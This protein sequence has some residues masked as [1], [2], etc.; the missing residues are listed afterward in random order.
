MAIVTFESIIPEILPSVP[1]CTDLIIVRALRRA[2]EEFLSK[3]LLWRINL[4]DHNVILG[5]VDVELEVPKSDLRIV[6]LKSIK[7]GTQETDIPQIADSQTPPNLS[8]TFCSLVDFG[9]TLRLTPV[10]TAAVT[11]KIRAVLSTTSKST[12]V[13][14]AVE[15]EIHE[16]LIDGSLARLYAMPGMPWADSSLAAYH[17]AIFQAAI[18]EMRGRAENNNGRAVRTVSYGG[19]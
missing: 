4:E 11:L 1:E 7:S 6:Q 14:S 12:G 3:S 10:P 2:S 18:I 13:D 5:L 17:G 8:Q 16:H 19:V 15:Q 9:K